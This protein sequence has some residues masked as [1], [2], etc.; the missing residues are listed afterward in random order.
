[1]RK[2]LLLLVIST[3]LILSSASASST[4]NS[5]GS[6]NISSIISQSFSGLPNEDF[7]SS[8]TVINNGANTTDIQILESGFGSLDLEF[9]ADDF[10][11]APGEARIVT[12][13]ILSNP[14]DEDLFNGTI[15]AQRDSNNKDSFTVSVNLSTIGKQLLIIESVKLDNILLQANANNTGFYPGQ[16]LKLKLTLHNNYEENDDPLID[17]IVDLNVEFEN[18]QDESKSDLEVEFDDLDIAIKPSSTEEIASKEFRIPFDL[19]KNKAYKLTVKGEFEDEQNRVFEINYSTFIVVDKKENQVGFSKFEISD[20]SLVCGDK[21]D[22]DLTFVNTGT[23]NIDDAYYVLKIG[24]LNLTYVS[25]FYDLSTSP[26]SGS[27]DFEYEINEKVSLQIPSKIK[28]KDYALYVEPYA[29]NFK[30]E[31]EAHL[32]KIRSCPS[33]N[34]DN[35]LDSDNIIDAVNNQN[36]N[37]ETKTAASEL[38]TE[39]K[40]ETIERQQNMNF[41]A[42]SIDSPLSKKT[43]LVILVSVFTFVF[44][45]LLIVL[46]VIMN[47]RKIGKVQ[48]K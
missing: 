17:S 11:L 38:G 46:I 1:M 27:S 21:I 36:I 13:E 45:I 20:D 6:I 3:F 32:V 2:I 34:S 35:L 15:T 28:P 26:T 39:I 30:S 4:P 10:T 14:E 23:N 44:I 5:K 12:F 24:E 42:D 19:T 16:P 8:F 43:F 9:S 37:T 47:N 7:E 25:D 29:K 31:T 18:F 33:F 41:I 22:I 48:K 40:S